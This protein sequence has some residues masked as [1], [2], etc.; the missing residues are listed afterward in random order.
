MK[1][2]LILNNK[3]VFLVVDLLGKFG[4]DGMMSCW[5]LYYQ[6]LI[7]LNGLEDMGLLNSPLANVCPFFGSLGIFFLG[8][9]WLPACFPVIR[10]LFKEFGFDFGRLCESVRALAQSDQ[11]CV[12]AS[13]RGKSYSESRLLYD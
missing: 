13:T 3:G 11:A 12:I 10:E 7:L 9:R 8:M 5:I 2:D 4:G 1:L 6:T